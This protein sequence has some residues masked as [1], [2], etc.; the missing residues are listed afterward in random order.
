MAAPFGVSIVPVA[1]GVGGGG[2]SSPRCDDYHQRHGD[3]TTVSASSI[4]IFAES[5]GGGGG[6]GAMSVAASPAP[7]A[8]T[9]GIGGDGGANGKGGNV[10]VT[11]FGDGIIHTQGFGSTGIMAQSVGARW[12][13][14]RRVLFRLGRPARTSPSRSAARVLPAATVAPCAIADSG[15][16]QLGGDNSVAIF[17]QSVGGGGG[18]GGVG[19][20][21]IGVPVFIGGD[22]GATGKGGDVT[23]TNT[24]QIRLT[25]NG[26][27]RHLRAVCRWRRRRGDGGHRW[28]RPGGRRRRVA[29]AVWSP[30]TATSP[31]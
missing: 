19:D 16:M 4:A 2:G 10:N 30:S 21:A 31:C 14:R 15:A 23:V 25:G 9:F 11:N 7:G 18:S 12:R 6:T 22:T 26:S 20:P 13:C 24:G 1:I 5:I 27:A 29:T 8:F 17:A 28:H 3:I